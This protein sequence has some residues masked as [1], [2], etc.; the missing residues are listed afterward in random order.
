SNALESEI[1]LRHDGQRFS[2]NGFGAGPFTCADHLSTSSDCATAAA[3]CAD[4]PGTG[5]ATVA[6]CCNPST[7]S[8]TFQT[9]SFSPLKAAE[10][11]DGMVPGKGPVNTDCHTE[12]LTTNAKNAPQF[13]KSYAT[14]KPSM[15]NITNFV[16]TCTDGDDCDADH[17]KNGTCIFNLLVAV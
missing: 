10:A 7:H 4:A 16:Q 5:H 8:W 3:N 13:D 9:C 12:W 15:P 6:N 2:L 11:M 17:T 1:V 14:K